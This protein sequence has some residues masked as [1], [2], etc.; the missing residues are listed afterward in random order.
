MVPADGTAAQ[1]RTADTVGGTDPIKDGAMGMMAVG[2][3]ATEQSYSRARGD[4]GYIPRLKSVQ[5]KVKERLGKA[6]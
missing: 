6:R 1:A 4:E 5:W 3:R 2:I